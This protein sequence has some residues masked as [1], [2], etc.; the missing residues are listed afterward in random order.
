MI[1]ETFVTGMLENNNFL[2]ID[3]KSKE[4]ILVDCSMDIEGVKEK[5]D[6]YGAKLKYILI[7]HGHFDHILGLN[8][9]AEQFPEAQVLAPVLDKEM[10]EKADEFVKMFVG[11]LGDVEVPK[12][13]KFIDENEEIFI[14][15]EKIK[16][17]STPG[18]TEGGVCYFVD[19]KLF[20]GDTIFLESYGRTD[21]P[22]GNYDELKNSI[23]KVL[24]MFD[25]NVEIYSGHGDSTS[26]GHEKQYNPIL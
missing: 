26:V 14:G 24:D 23:K 19:N 16:V 25:D 5:L 12:I 1:L 9:I 10:I 7:T 15:S 3:E 22:G 20:S 6:E 4:A 11:F 2:L 21:L 8:E 18:H 13:S 17:I